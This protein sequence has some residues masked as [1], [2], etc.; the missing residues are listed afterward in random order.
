[1]GAYL[2]VALLSIFSNKEERE[3]T[4]LN[5]G[6]QQ[7]LITEYEIWGNFQLRMTHK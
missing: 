6:I 3:T 4:R 5:C 1:M 2:L 7:S